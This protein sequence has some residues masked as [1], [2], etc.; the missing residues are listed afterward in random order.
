MKKVLI[1]I[2]AIGFIVTTGC[3]K[4]NYN[5]DNTEQSSNANSLKPSAQDNLNTNRPDSD[6]NEPDDMNA[7]TVENSFFFKSNVSQ[8]NYTGKFLFSEETVE[9]DVKLYIN[10]VA[11]LKYG[12]LYE[13]RLDSVKD[14]P[15]DRLGLG[16]FFVQKDKI[17]R[18]VQ[19][20]ENLD[21]LKRSEEVPND[22][23]IVCQDKEIKDTLGEDEPG[24]HQYIKVDG[25][26]RKYY[27]YSNQVATGY[28]ESF[29]WE[30]NKGLINYR[31]GFGAE[32]ESIELQLS[33]E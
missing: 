2:L 4:P 27:S 26:K 11:N 1:I 3:A 23:A 15:D 8:L 13:L 28:Y 30:K 24:W 21:K 7:E 32:R 31:S 20:E 16:Y 19:T 12:K 9:K 33:N 29:I 18:V 6:T 17:Y 25:N 10:V 14:V 5:R 22:S